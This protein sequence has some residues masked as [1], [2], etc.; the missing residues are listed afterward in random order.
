MPKNYKENLKEKK[1][2]MLKK[3]SKFFLVNLIFS[4][5]FLFIN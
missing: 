2:K 3:K 1:S 4:L 5:L